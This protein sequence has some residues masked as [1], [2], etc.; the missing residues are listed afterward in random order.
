MD[1]GLEFQK[2]E[3]E[4]PSSNLEILC[5]PFLRQRKQLSIFGLKFAHNW[6]FGSEFQ[7]SKSIFGTN[8][9]EILCAP[10]FRQNREFLIFW[11]KFARKLIL[12]L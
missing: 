2:S 3:S 8:I 11:P 1:F 10:I 12:V 6:I 4:F 9:L 5:E 7:K